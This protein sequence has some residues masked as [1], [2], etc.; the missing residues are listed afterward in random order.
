MELLYK[1]GGFHFVTAYQR[2]LSALLEILRGR[3]DDTESPRPESVVRERADD[4]RRR[5]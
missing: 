3:E 2:H 1:T 4:L 5:L